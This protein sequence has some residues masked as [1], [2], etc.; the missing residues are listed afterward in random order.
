[1]LF[2]ALGNFGFIYRWF[3]LVNILLTFLIG[4]ALA[5]ILIK[6]TRTPQH[7]RGLVIGCCSAG[8]QKFEFD[9]LFI[10]IYIF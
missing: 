6:I 10:G 9:T 5:W 1:L 7:L 4:T 2:S 8:R 3:M